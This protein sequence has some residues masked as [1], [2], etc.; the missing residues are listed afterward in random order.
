MD[1][2]VALMNLAESIHD[3]GLAAN[4]HEDDMI[5]AIPYCN[6]ESEGKNYEELS[7]VALVELV[8]SANEPTLVDPDDDDE[9]LVAPNTTFRDVV[10]MLA[11]IQK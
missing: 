1:V 6:L 9:P 11:E 7:D 8:V 10:R 3:L 5:D 2:T 4:V